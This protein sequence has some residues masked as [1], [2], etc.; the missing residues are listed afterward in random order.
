MDPRTV[1]VLE[2]RTVGPDMVA[3]ELEAPAGFTAKPGQF[4]LIRAPP[5]DA[6]STDR[7]KPVSEAAGRHYT[8]SS[9]DT[10][11]SFEITIEVGPDGT[12]SPWLAGRNPGDTIHIEGPFGRTY[13]DGGDVAVIAGGPG[14]GAAAGIGDRAVNT[15]HEAIMVLQPPLAHEQRLAKLAMTGATVFVVTTRLADAVGVTVDAPQ[16]LVFGFRDFIDQVRVALER[17]G[18][19]P[20]SVDYENFGPR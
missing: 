17:I 7:E 8:I 14:I 9:P 2:T 19:D 5:E 4:I 6:V 3:L 18:V 11:E 16:I 10:I 15:G 20:D 1:D 13:Y 12:L